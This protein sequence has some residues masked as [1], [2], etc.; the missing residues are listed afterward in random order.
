MNCDAEGRCR[1]CSGVIVYGSRECVDNCPKGYHEEWSTLVDYMGRLCR[2]RGP[3]WLEDGVGLSGRRLAV[4]VGTCSGL[5]ISILLLFG[6]FFYIRCCRTNQM[7]SASTGSKHNSVPNDSAGYGFSHRYPQ[8]AWGND[9][10]ERQEFLQQLSSLKPE[11]PVFLAMLNDTRRKYR[12]ICSKNGKTDSRCK[13]YRVVLKD[14][15]QILSLLN[16]KD[17]QTMSIPEDWKKLFSWGERVLK[18]YKKQHSLVAAALVQEPTKVIQLPIQVH[19]EPHKDCSERTLSGLVSFQPN[20]KSQQ[21][22]P[23][24][25]NIDESVKVSNGNLLFPGVTDGNSHFLNDM[26]QEISNRPK[27][28]IDMVDDVG[29]VIRVRQNPWSPEFCLDSNTQSPVSDE[30]TEH[31]QW[32]YSAED[33][34]AHLGHRPQDEIT[35]EL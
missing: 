32:E 17:L 34:F 29:E 12:K 25:S 27:I 14:L 13:A 24:I 4:V 11:A 18:R 7:S 5:F 15:C 20:G 10:I 35:T 31:L 28:V 2:E 22:Y 16:H 6:A 26:R 19:C 3:W 8:F 30:W 21:G 33:E 23:K 1:K 9:E